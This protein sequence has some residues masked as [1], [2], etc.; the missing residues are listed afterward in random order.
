MKLSEMTATD[1]LNRTADFLEKEL[2]D[3]GVRFNMRYWFT[4]SKKKLETVDKI[5]PA[6]SVVPT[7]G[8]AACA[9]GSATLV[10][11]FM[12]RQGLK[13]VVE[14]W[15]DGQWDCDIRYRGQYGMDA[16]AKFFKISDEDASYLFEPMSYN[17][18]RKRNVISRL[19]QVAKKYEGEE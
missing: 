9:A 19:R 4:P 1:R 14:Y 8:T 12:G 11:E 13:L 6:R 10:P 16:C 5:T 7:C 17:D 2:D 15:G 3:Y 18:P